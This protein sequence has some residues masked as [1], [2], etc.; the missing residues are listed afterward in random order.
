MF[1]RRDNLQASSALC[2]PVPSPRMKRWRMR[3]GSR[4][5][6]AVPPWSSIFAASS[7][8]PPSSKRRDINVSKC[9]A[10]RTQWLSAMPAPR[11]IAT[12]SAVTAVAAF[13]FASDLIDAVVHDDDGE[14]AQASTIPMVVRQP[15]AI[16]IEPSPS[17]RS[18]PRSRLEEKRATERDRAGKA[19]AAE[20]V[21]IL[22]AVAGG[23]EIEIGIADARD[24]GFVALEFRHQ[25]PGQ[26]GAV[27][28]LD[29]RSIDGGSGHVRSLT[30]AWPRPA[31]FRR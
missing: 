30:S 6:C 27:E 21:E 15:S 9:A 5:V 12:T 16:G 28:H 26:V 8:G 29:I 25:T 10:S 23:I 31:D 22:R 7:S 4:G 18:A 20:H 24:H 3:A 17:A 13:C 2:R 11:A 1:L 19:H 14:V